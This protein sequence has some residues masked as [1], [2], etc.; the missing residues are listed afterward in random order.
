MG[1]LLGALTVLI[2]LLTAILVAV[3][4][5]FQQNRAAKSGRH[6]ERLAAQ[7]Q[8]LY[9][10]LFF[11]TGQNEQLQKRRAIIQQAYKTEYEGKRWA[12]SALAS[13]DEECKITIDVM[14]TYTDQ[15]QE[16]NTRMVR[17]VEDN[18]AMIHA[19]DVSLLQEFVTDW[20]RVNL[21]SG[22]LP[23]RVARQIELLVFYRQEFVDR[24]AARYSRLSEELRLI[25]DFKPY[26]WW[27]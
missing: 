2:P 16:N 26:K 18:Y 25:A 15:V 8:R 14:N 4:N 24:I 3:L 7:I 19:E 21:E 12:E 1:Y 23:A 5:H 17:I 11:F 6:A 10:P 9:G 20:K 22:K 13:I 27:F